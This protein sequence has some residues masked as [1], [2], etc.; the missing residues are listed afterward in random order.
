M[1]SPTIVSMQIGISLSVEKFK[2]EA[3]LLDD[4]VDF[5]E[6]HLAGR[7]DVT[8]LLGSKHKLLAH[9]AEL[10]RMCFESLELAKRLSVDKAVVHFFTRSQIAFDEKILMLDRL[11]KKAV[12]YGITLCLENTEES[13]NVLKKIFERK[14]GLKFC[15][16][17]GHANLFSNNP[18]DFIR[19]FSDRMKHI[20][21]S[22]NRGGDSEED[23][24]HIPPGD[25]TINFQCIFSELKAV[26]YNKTLTL[27]LHP[28]SG[29]NAKMESLRILRRLERG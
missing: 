18:M 17:V 29:I 1:L 25:G 7:E 2:E 8:I 14:S 16:D 20:H 19:A 11:R 12:E 9:L 28:L 27:E 26:N 10:D 6:V 5:I 24:L 21:I 4:L 15:L 13:V 22:D 23:D 3:D